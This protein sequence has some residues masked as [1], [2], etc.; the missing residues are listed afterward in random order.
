MVGRE[1]PL[2]NGEPVANQALSFIPLSLIHAQKTQRD[3]TFRDIAVIRTEDALALIERRAQQG[4]RPIEFA[5]LSVN[6]S[7]R[8]IELGLYLRLR[9]QGAR[10]LHAAIHQRDNSQVVGGT[11]FFIASLEQ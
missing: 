2:A 3:Q 11:G 4:I 1:F 9:I 5:E 6:A 10:F 7:Q 8:E